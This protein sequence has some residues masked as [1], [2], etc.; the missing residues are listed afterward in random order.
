MFRSAALEALLAAFRCDPSVACLPTPPP[1]SDLSAALTGAAEEAAV[2]ALARAA[3]TG[4]VAAVDKHTRS[5]AAL[6]TTTPATATPAAAPAAT[7]TATAGAEAGAV[8]GLAR[9]EETPGATTVAGVFAHPSDGARC[10]EVAATF[11]RTP[12][13]AAGPAE[14]MAVFVARELAL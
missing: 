6:A 5:E 8:P 14:L 2:A 4:L 7:T 10:L 1:R 9:F 3:A 12:A 13:T 11:T